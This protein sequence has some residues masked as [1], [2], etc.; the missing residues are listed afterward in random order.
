LIAS[1]GFEIEMVDVGDTAED[2]ARQTGQT[3]DNRGADQPRKPSIFIPYP[4]SAELV[5]SALFSR[6]DPIVKEIQTIY[7][8]ETLQRKI[9]GGESDLIIPL[10]SIPFFHGVAD[11]TA[12]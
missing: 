1:S 12:R 6:S 2:R 11:T 5:K 8:D 3:Q 10:S 4:F 9:K 7:K